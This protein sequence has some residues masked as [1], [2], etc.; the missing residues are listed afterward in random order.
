MNVPSSAY[1]MAAVAH[2]AVEVVGAA[3][4]AEV[5]AGSVTAQAVATDVESTVA[6]AEITLVEAAVAQAVVAEV[7]AAVADAQGHQGID[8]EG[9]G[10][11]WR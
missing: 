3:E 2:V 8:L 10:A 1:V 4:A 11:G 7:E 5:A 6:R 9:A